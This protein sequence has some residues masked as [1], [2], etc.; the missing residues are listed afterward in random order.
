[1]PS[2]RPPQ[3]E[4]KST[5]FITGPFCRISGLVSVRTHYSF[6]RRLWLWTDILDWLPQGEAIDSGRDTQLSC[7]TFPSI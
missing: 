6:P 1:M 3:P 4:N 7:K 5:Y 2:D